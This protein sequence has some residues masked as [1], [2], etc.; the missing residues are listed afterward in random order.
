MDAD[1]ENFICYE[2]I[3]ENYLKL[4]IERQGNICKCSY[5]DN[6]EIECYPLLDVANRIDSAFEQH[7]LRS[8]E[9]PPDYYS[10]EHLKSLDGWEPDGLPVV[11]AIADAAEISE[12]AASDIQ[13]ILAEKHYSRSAAEIGETTE[14]DIDSF[15][16]RKEPDDREWQSQW[17]A[18]ET[19]L[20]T[21]SRF[22][23]KENEQLLASV[24]DN[25]NVLRTLDEKPI[26]KTIGPDTDITS[27]FRARAFQSD[28]KLE[29]ALQQPEKELGPPPPEFATAGR[30]NARGISVFYGATKVDTALCEIRPPVGSKVAVAKF[31]L[32]RQLK[33]LDLTALSTTTVEGS[34]FDISYSELVSKTMFLRKLSQRITRPIM[35]D[36]EHFDYLATQVI[37]DFLA[38]EYGF[39]GIIFPSAQ[40]ADGVNIIFFHHASGVEPIKHPKGTKVDVSLYDWYD[41]EQCPEYRITTSIPKKENE[42]KEDTFYDIPWF[43]HIESSTEIRKDSLAIDLESITIEHVSSV[44]IVTSSYSV[45]S[46]SHE[47]RFQQPDNTS[48]FTF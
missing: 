40:S 24:F 2:C 4:E 12:E 28:D 41:E 39:D 44:H 37:A 48:E 14:F 29:K 20:K 22:F 9:S 7:F 33:V 8:S 36:D 21:K 34:I 17:A 11:E 13:E 25:L 30:M 3:G 45:T 10:I 31:N 47:E 19:S 32:M 15:Y 42:K 46:T 18:F 1:T 26:I 43:H 38:A 5:C 35:P 6:D 16:D 23:S 27:L